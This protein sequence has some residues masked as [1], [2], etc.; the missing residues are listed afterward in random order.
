MNAKY[1]CATLIL[2][3]QLWGISSRYGVD[4]IKSL[5]VDDWVDLAN[6]NVTFAVVR[7]INQDGSID[8]TGIRNLRN[9]LEANFTELSGYMYPCVQSSYFARVEGIECLDPADQID[10]LVASLEENVA[11]LENY[12]TVTWLPTSAPTGSPTV[13]AQPTYAPTSSPS[14]IPTIDATP[15]P[16]SAP[17][18]P[19]SETPSA[20][21]TTLTANWTVAPTMEPTTAA[22]TFSPTQSPTLSQHPTS[23]PTNEPGQNTLVV[24]RIFLMVEDESPPRYFDPDQAVNQ[25]YFTSLYRRAHE[26]GYQL[27]VFTTK[28]YWE[29]LMV[30]TDGTPLIYERE[31]T[32]LWIPR[33]DGVANMDFFVPFGNW[34]APYMK[35]FSGGSSAARRAAYTWRVNENYID[36]TYYDLDGLNAT[37]VY[38]I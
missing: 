3:L 7:L 30:Q 6:L 12:T 2:I 22:P 15:M 13:A 25:E 10:T 23:M 37:I 26:N 31:S 21:P 8:G 20:S 36:E 27:G 35:Q 38:P 32:P 9:A 33:Y 19:P 28:R 14:A 4:L 34:T 5:T 29:E 17:S 1:L 16:S 24:R 18:E 11:K